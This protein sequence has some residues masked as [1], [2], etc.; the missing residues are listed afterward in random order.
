[1]FRK[2]FLRETLTRVGRQLART[3][4]VSTFYTSAQLEK[5]FATL[6]LSKDQTYC[7]TL[8]VDPKTRND[9]DSEEIQNARASLYRYFA[10]QILE[11]DIV[12]NRF[13][14]FLKIDER[15]PNGAHTRIGVN[16]N[17]GPFTS[18]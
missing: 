16:E 6:K 13:S 5:V 15:S 1:M 12:R 17:I 14:L 18:S 7:V 8:F 10:P 9:I 3:Y 11:V 4:G 2:F